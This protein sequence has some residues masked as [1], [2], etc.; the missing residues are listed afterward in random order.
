M[1]FK[2]LLYISLICGVIAGAGIFFNVPNYA[3]FTIPRLFAF[4]GM[5]SVLLTFKDK[6]VG[7]MLKLGGIMINLMPLLGSLLATN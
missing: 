4:V 3:N 5:I 1:N 2:I 7:F 6:S